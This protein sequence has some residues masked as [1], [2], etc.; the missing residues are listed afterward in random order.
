[1]PC[2]RLLEQCSRSRVVGGV[3]SFERVRVTPN[4]HA[5]PTNLLI[6]RK[7]GEGCHC[8]TFYGFTVLNSDACGNLVR[9]KLRRENIEISV[10][11]IRVLQIC[12]L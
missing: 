6:L 4:V 1:M 5:T 12:L 9:P 10:A 11:L 7:F 8:D 3:I 2:R